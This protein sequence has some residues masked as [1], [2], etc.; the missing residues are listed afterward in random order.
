[1]DG[2]DLGRLMAAACIFDSAHA[3]NNITYW[4]LMYYKGSYVTL[5]DGETDDWIPCKSL[6]KCLLIL[7]RMD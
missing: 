5:L 3:F 4:I 2:K 7:D 6:G 1:M